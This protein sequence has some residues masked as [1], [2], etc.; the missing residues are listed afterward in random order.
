M[1]KDFEAER[2]RLSISYRSFLHQE[3]GIPVSVVKC[4][5]GVEGGE[6]PKEQTERKKL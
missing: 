1:L 6:K 5:G 2:H 3:E 4:G